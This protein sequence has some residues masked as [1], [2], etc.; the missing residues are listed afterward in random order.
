MSVAS[1]VSRSPP[2]VAT[3]LAPLMFAVLEHALVFPALG[4][5]AVSRAPPGL[6]EIL[7]AAAGIQG[8]CA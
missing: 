5:E 7:A 3:A 1:P 6:A 2:S 8:R 4:V